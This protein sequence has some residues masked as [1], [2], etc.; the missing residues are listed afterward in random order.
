[1]ATVFWD[2][3]GVPLIEF[4]PIGTTI[5]SLQRAIKNRRSGKLTKGARL[6]HDNGRPH[7]SQQAKYLIEG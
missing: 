5:N 1:M 2:R 6:H 3:R 7:V 4:M